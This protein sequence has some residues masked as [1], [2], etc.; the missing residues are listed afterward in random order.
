MTGAEVT[1]A[2]FGVRVAA[3]ALDLTLML[4]AAALLTWLGIALQSLELDNRSEFYAAVVA[5]WRD[6]LLLP[7]AVLVVI[8]LALSWWRVL[9]TPGQLLMGCRVLRRRR[10]APLDPLVALWRAVAM[11]ALAGPAVVPLLTLFLDRRRRAA[12]DW[13]SDSVVVEEDESRVSLEEWLSRLG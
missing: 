11:L 4:C 2:R 1:Y 8:A 13:L 7:A 3:G 12:H 6:V 10:A 9:A 5:L